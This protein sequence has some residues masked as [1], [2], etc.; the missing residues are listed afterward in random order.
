[1]RER[2]TQHK[3]PFL[4]FWRVGSRGIVVRYMQPCQIAIKMAKW[5]LQHCSIASRNE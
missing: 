3:L 4:S 5:W 2:A 1:M